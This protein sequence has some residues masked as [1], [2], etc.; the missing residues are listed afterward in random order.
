MSSINAVS[1]ISST[2]KTAATTGAG[3]VQSKNLSENFM[4]LLVAQLKNQDPL[5]PMDNAQMTSQ[6]AQLNSLEQLT[7]IGDLLASQAGTSSLSTLSQAASALGKTAEVSLPTSGAISTVDG[8]ATID[9]DFGS[10]SPYKATLTAKD[11]NTGTVW[12]SWPLDQSSGSID[13]TNVPSGSQLSVTSTNASGEV[14]ASASGSGMLTQSLKVSQTVLVDNVV[15]LQSA[16]GV[17]AP[18]SQLV[19]LKAS[20]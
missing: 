12:G 11:P 16:E 13:L 17:R 19:G 4:Q 6:L 18:W 15:Y 8:K 3:S 5:S 2:A 9:Y 14:I 10:Q 1:P 7:K 20:S